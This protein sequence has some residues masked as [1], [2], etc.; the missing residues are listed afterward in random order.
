MKRIYMGDVIDRRPRTISLIALGETPM[1]RAMAVFEIPIGLRYSLSK[2]SPGL[3][4]SS[5][6]ISYSVIG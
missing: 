5:I 6:P 1:A 2:I 4:G 3:M